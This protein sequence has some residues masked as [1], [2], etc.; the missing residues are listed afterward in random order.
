MSVIH[1]MAPLMVNSVNSSVRFMGDYYT[2][3]VFLFD[4]NPPILWQP[5]C[6]G[7]G[8]WAFPQGWRWKCFSAVPFLFL[9]HLY[10]R[11]VVF[12]LRMRWGSEREESEDGLQL[13]CHARIQVAAGRGRRTGGGVMWTQRRTEGLMTSSHA[14][15][16]HKR[17]R[18]RAEGWGE[19]KEE[20]CQMLH[21]KL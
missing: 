11:L 3:L 4:N 6:T 14:H 8:F 18:R 20:Q 19:N 10:Q 1:E 21:G 16:S 17:T 2:G 12:P 7:P 15:S 13:R 9:L 5:L